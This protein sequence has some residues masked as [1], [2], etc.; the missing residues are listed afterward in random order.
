MNFILD[1]R[2]A[3]SC[4][5][6]GEWPL[7]SVLLKNNAHYP[8]LILV[9]RT[10]GIQDIDELSRDHRII[11]MDEICFISSI[12]RSQFNPDKINVGAL[13]NKVSQLHI[14]IVGRFKTDPLW[15]EGIWQ[16]GQPEEPYP[17]DEY[18]RLSSH[19]AGLLSSPFDLKRHNPST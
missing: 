1:Q 16:S 5:L 8:W 17:Q 2:I 14:H 10:P 19:L 9:P 18:E 7:S 15:P 6:L 4:R 3:T 11:L 13:G 12:V